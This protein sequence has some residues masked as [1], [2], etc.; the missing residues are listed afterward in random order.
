MAT[1]ET[2]LAFVDAI[3]AR[4]VDRILGLAA[5]D[6][7]FIDAYGTVVSAPALRAA[8][9]GYFGFM[10]HYG[11]EVEEML[12]EGDRAAL[13]GHAWGSLDV[14]P[15]G[16]RQWRRPTAWK[17]LVAGDRV[18]LWQVYVDTKIVFDLLSSA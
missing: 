13:F 3:N 14:E 2:I 11:I 15:D 4:D 10:R 5:E 9:A 8:W 6:H 7:E 12:C 18:R 1:R 16:P 17:V